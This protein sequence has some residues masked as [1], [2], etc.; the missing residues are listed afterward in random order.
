MNPN[1]ILFSQRERESRRSPVVRGWSGG[2]M[3]L[4]NLSVPRPPTN[5]D[6]SRKR[7]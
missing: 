3:V 7:A 6:N 4:G 1:C 5:L 2:A